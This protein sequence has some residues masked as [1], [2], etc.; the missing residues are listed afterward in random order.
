MK[1]FLAE[2]NEDNFLIVKS[3]L[4]KLDEPVELIWAKDGQIAIDML[5]EPI[6]DIDIFLI[7]IEMPYLNGVEVTMFINEQDEYNGIPI[8]ALTA[9]VYAEMK[10]MYL[11]KGFDYILEKP[12]ERKELLE[13]LQ[14]SVNLS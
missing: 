5:K 3:N 2:D 9:S 6:N 4:R 13:I 7:D 12:F 1:I 10:K 11:E 8:I 14:R